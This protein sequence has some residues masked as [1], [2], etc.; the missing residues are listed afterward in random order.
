MSIA[1]DLKI[2]YHLACAPIRGRDHQERLD[3][4]YA[5]QASGYDAFRAHLLKGRKELYD[6]IAVPDGGVWIEMGGGTGS[7]LEYLENRLD[8]LSAVHVVDLSNSL[9]TV[10][11]QRI[12]AK[13][14]HNVQVHHQDV[15]LFDLHG[16]KAD[17]I[18]FSY[19]LTMIPDWIAALENARALLKPGGILAVVDFYVARKYPEPGHQRHS[20]FTRTFW[21]AWL[22][23]DNV[24]PN[25]D[26]APY[27]HRNFDTIYFSEKRARMR[28]FP[29]AG[30]PY[31]MYLGKAR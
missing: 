16:T 1:S 26:H 13:S 9:L 14:W 31:F 7:N 23:L 17:V 30:V 25:P 12:A 10:A 21:P 2:L 3:S 24:F 20:W 29:L 15:T 27:L 22:G 6:L 5:G 19:S 18:T 11:R 28:Y 8:R 4:F